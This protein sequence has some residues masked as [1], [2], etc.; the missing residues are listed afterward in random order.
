M[1]FQAVKREIETFHIFLPVRTGSTR[2]QVAG[3]V[4]GRPS[5]RQV[6]MLH[7]FRDTPWTLVASKFY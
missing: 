6:M 5:D 3:R 1:S 4:S 7:M 2:A